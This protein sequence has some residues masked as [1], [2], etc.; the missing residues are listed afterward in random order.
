MMNDMQTMKIF[1]FIFKEFFNIYAVNIIIT[2]IETSH[3]IIELERLHEKIQEV[4]YNSISKSYGSSLMMVQLQTVDSS[5]VSLT[6][7][8]SKLVDRR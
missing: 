5:F 3:F 7:H 2:S 8:F 6:G 1:F 4:K